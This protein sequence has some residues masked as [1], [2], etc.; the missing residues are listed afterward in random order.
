[1]AI[2]LSFLSLGFVTVLVLRPHLSPLYYVVG[3]L[4][5]VGSSYG[6]SIRSTVYASYYG[7]E[8]L[9]SIQTIASSLTVLGSAVGPFPFGYAKDHLGSYRIPFLGSAAMMLFT[10]FL[11][12]LFAKKPGRLS[13]KGS[14]VE[15]P[16]SRVNSTEDADSA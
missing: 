16:Y 10:V 14:S 1:M 6:A 12:L 3:A 9:G 15:I 8:N 7:K 4:I 13:S 2:G 11:V 5:G